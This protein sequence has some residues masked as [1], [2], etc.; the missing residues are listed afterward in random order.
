MT[1][2]LKTTRYELLRRA[3]KT[4]NDK[5]RIKDG[6]WF[7]TFAVLVDTN[8]KI[9]SYRGGRERESSIITFTRLC[10]PTR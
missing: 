6:Q 9:A 10:R 8:P 7:G 4:V 2:V 5:I 1:P 3:F